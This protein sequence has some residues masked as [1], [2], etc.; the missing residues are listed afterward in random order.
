MDL[1]STMSAALLASACSLALAAVP[2]A[3]QAPVA[4]TQPAPSAFNPSE[5]NPSLPDP[6]SPGTAEPGSPSQA[7]LEYGAYLALAG[8]CLGCHTRPGGAPFAGGLAL[9]TPFGTLYTPNITAADKAGIGTFS[10]GDFLRAMHDGVGPDGT[11]YYPAFPYASFRKVPDDDLLAIKDYLFSLP[12]SDHRPPKAQLRWPFDAR[13]LLFGWQELYLQPGR[14]EPRADKSDEWNRG[15][16]LVQGLGH[17][18]AC[19][20]P[21]SAEGET[22]PAAALG[23]SAPRRWFAPNPAPDL[24]EVLGGENGEGRADWSVDALAEALRTGTM[25]PA[26]QAP[27]LTTELVHANLSRLA[28][29]DLRAMAVYLKDQPALAA[30]APSAQR[31]DAAVHEQGRALYAHYCSACHQ[32][33][34]QGIAPYFPALRGNQVMTSA[35][36]GDALKS[37]LLGAPADPSDAYSAHV[38]M[39]SFGSLLDDR[40]IAIIAS[41]IRASWGNQAAPVSAEQVGEV[42]ARGR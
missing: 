18:S 23:A 3:A 12:P 26:P 42:R 38:V 5:P 28:A 16:Y 10:D 35:E 24:S 19:H 9:E 15:A 39:P 30:D 22:E 11:P 4:E 36:P 32:A 2:A 25:R 33:Y 6:T 27:A 37:I 29:S 31:L 20:V 1:R 14:F 8:N 17:C 34:G 40:Q 13:E 41:F 7:R 21:S